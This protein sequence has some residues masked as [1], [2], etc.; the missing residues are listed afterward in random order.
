MNEI[1]DAHKNFWQAQAGSHPLIGVSL[2]PYF[3]LQSFRGLTKGPLMP[4]DVH[5]APFLDQMDAEFETSQKL[6]G[7][8][9]WAAAPFSGIPWM[10]AIL[11]C[12][13]FVGDET[14]W[15][16]PLEWNWDRLHHLWPEPDNPWLQKLLAFTA[17]LVGRAD[18]R[19]AIGL[20]LMRG[21]SDIMA[22]LM[23]HERF[24][25]ELYDHPSEMKQMAWECAQ[26]W[27]QVAN[28]Q[29]ALIPRWQNGCCQPLRQV[30][31]PGPC[32]ET[33]EDAA[34]MLGPAVFRE[35]LLPGI[36]HIASNFDYPF[37]HIHSG[38]LRACESVL[39]VNELAAIE[40][41]VDVAGPTLSELLPYLA[42]IQK[43]KPLIIHGM[44]DAAQMVEA[45][46]RLRPEGLCLISRVS[47]VEEGN[48]LLAAVRKW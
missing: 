23:G 12:P 19:Y 14:I 47:S 31:A 5:I 25:L 32:L 42:K 45:L 13:I 17:A 26:I 30:W 15:S 46:S 40:V 24:C 44:F 48:Q 39:E 3:P 33:Q 6:R 4:E 37:F 38:S 29:L 28:A 21:P 7:R 11:G 18:G 43:A 2:S 8:A 27:V 20:T 41:T 16:E 10:E 35:L 34:I 9:I 22:A 36:K 1:L